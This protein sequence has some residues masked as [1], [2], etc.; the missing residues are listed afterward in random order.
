MPC[1]DD[2]PC[3]DNGDL[4]RTLTD[5]LNETTKMLCTVLED[6][7]CA[8]EPVTLDYLPTDIV[9]WWE[10]HKKRDAARLAIIRARALSKLTPEERDALGVK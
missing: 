9:A 10:E 8:E 4:I 3:D 5:R 7:E 1:V 6:I 2:R